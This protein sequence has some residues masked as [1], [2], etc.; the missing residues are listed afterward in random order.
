M[1]TKPQICR[2]IEGTL[3]ATA[4]GEAGASA[5]QRVDAHVARCAPCRAELGHYRAID[6]LARALPRTETPSADA[7]AALITRLADLRRRLMTYGI[8]PSPLGRVLIARSEEGVALVEY[9]GAATS[10]RGSRLAGT[11]GVEL[12]EDGVEVERLHT[13]LVD[14]LAGRRSRLDW[15]LDLRLASSEFH[16]AVLAETARVPYGAVTS[17]TRI[18]H[19]LG[20]PA[21]VRAVAQALRW[22][23]LPIVVPCHRIVGASGSLTGYAGNRLALKQRLLSVEGVATRRDDHDLRVARDRMYVR[24]LDDREYCVPTCGSLAKKTLARLTLFGTREGAE[25]AGLAPCT[26]CRP[27][28]HPLA[29]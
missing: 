11:A 18:A 10:V 12:E 29:R 9:L 3:L 25:A 28:L 1:T 20:R 6:S 21:A 23:P 13:E 19:E 17:Y 14:Y 27:D 5:R 8:F 4:T 7:R 2:D 22:N 16:R 26:T 15:P 24:D